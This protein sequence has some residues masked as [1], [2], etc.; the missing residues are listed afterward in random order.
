MFDF[1]LIDSN[2]YEF[3]HYY[4]CAL[5]NMVTFHA[6]GCLDFIIMVN[7]LGMIVVFE[8]YLC[9]MIFF[10]PNFYIYLRMYRMILIT[11]S[12][13]LCT[14]FLRP[15]HKGDN[16]WLVVAVIALLVIAWFI[17]IMKPSLRWQVLRTYGVH[18]HLINLLEDLYLGTQADV[19]R[20]GHLGRIFPVTSGVR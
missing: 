8:H 20:G 10:Q 16:G 15:P 7:N 4:L 9:T 18:A 19:R 11:L 17:I 5:C 2:P 1:A 3:P 6:L 13:V 12:Q 14:K